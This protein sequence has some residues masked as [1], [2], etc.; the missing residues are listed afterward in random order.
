[1]YMHDEI[2]ERFAKERGLSET[3]KQQY[4]YRLKNYC[5]FTGQTLSELLDEAEE[6]EEQG[7]RWKKR[8]LKQKL[9]DYR[10]YLQENF[11]KHTVNTYFQSVQTFYRHH[12]IEIHELVALNQK[13]YNIPEPI[14]FKDLPDREIIRHSL[15]ISDPVMNAVILFISSSGSA[16]TETTNLTIQDFIDA[17]IEYHNTDDINEV[18]KKLKNKNDV[19]PMFKIRRQKTNKHYYTFCSPEAV[20]SILNHLLIRNDD[21]KPESRLFKIHPSYLVKKFVD[22]NEEMDLGKKGS[23]NRF[24]SHMLRK[25]HSSNLYNAGMTLD[26]IDALQGRGK[27][28]THSAYF[29]EDPEKLRQRYIEHMDAVTINWNVNNLDIKSLE[30]LD[31][32][33]K[34]EEKEKEVESLDERL[35]NLEKALGMNKDLLDKIDL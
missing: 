23:Y 9:T 20:E 15:L 7:I 6:E 8:K 26:E 19:V 14:N 5:N 25:F 1:M 17:T 12:E 35:S 22:L 27:D 24:R 4:N 2:F 34:Y 28:S 29:M 18:I 33:N 10:L 11:L 32:E 21:L 16:R 3:S 31:L 30:Y 13:A